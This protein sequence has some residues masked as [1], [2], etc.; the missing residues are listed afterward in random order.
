MYVAA[1]GSPMST[2][3]RPDVF[4]ARQQGLCAE[5][6]SGAQRVIYIK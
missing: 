6:T 5:N 1:C 3:C 2:H 4:L